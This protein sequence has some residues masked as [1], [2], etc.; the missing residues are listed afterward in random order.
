MEFFVEALFFAP[1]L[2][3]LFEFLLFLFETFLLLDVFFLF[4][5]EVWVVVWDLDF[6][7]A[8]ERPVALPP[9]AFFDRL[10]S[11]FSAFAILASSD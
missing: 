10:S 8:A 1:A 6:V 7:A 4:L 11:F 3:S 5:L 2:V 9:L